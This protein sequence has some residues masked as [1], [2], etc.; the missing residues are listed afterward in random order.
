MTDINVTDFASAGVVVSDAGRFISAHRD[1]DAA[2]RVAHQIGAEA[3]R[4]TIFVGDRVG[5]SFNGHPR[6]G[7]VTVAA[8]NK[9]TVRFEQASTGTIERAFFV[10]K[11]D[12]FV[13][14]KVGA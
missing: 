9:V 6:V 3:Q 4:H 12:R 1:F 10:D 7:R 5:F 2:V 13:T 14:P 8:G 11:I